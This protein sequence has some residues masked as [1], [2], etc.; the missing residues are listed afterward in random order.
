MRAINSS[1]K[2]TTTCG[3]VFNF[4]FLIFITSLPARNNL[5]QNVFF[6]QTHRR[7]HCFRGVGWQWD[8]A[9]AYVYR[10]TQQISTKICTNI[11][12]KYSK[13]SKSEFIFSSK[14]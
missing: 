4:K 3:N 2:F 11:F 14:K 7:F 5:K 12:N 13:K 10:P 9:W 1:V 6:T 8:G